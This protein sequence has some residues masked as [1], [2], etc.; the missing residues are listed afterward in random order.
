MRSKKLYMLLCVVAILLLVA[1]SK[2]NSS[3]GGSSS[4]PQSTA[5]GNSAKP[6]E[7]A[8]TKQYKG[9]IIISISKDADNVNAAAFKSLEAAYKKVQPDVKLVWEPGGASSENYKTWLGTQLAGSTPRP[10]IVSGNYQPGY[11]KYADFDKY[12]SRVNPY[13][14]NKWDQ[15][16]NFDFNISFDA[17][18]RRVMLPTQA[19]HIMWFY[20]KDIFD[21]L[22]IKPPQNWDELVSISDKIQKAG[23]IPIA[24][25]YNVKLPQ[26]LHEIYFDQYHKD[27]NNVVRAQ[28][29][30]YNYDDQ[31]DGVFQYN[32]NDPFIETKYTYNHNRF[33]K[34]LVDGAISF[35]NPG[36]IEMIRNL[37]KVFPKYSQK[38]L[39]VADSTADYTLW[40][41]QK[42]AMIIDSSGKLIGI[43][44]DMKNLND[45]VRLEKL[46][47]SDKSLK[48]FNWSTFENPSM[49]G[50]YVQGNVRSVESSTGEYVSIIDKNQEKTEMVMDFVMFW[51]SKPGYQAWIDGQKEIGSF[52]LGGPIM[53]NNVELPAEISKMFDGIQ[54]LGNA[55][56]ELNKNMLVGRV[57]DLKTTGRD[58]FKQALEGSITPEDYAKKFQKLWIDNIGVIT[59][60]AGLTQEN[61]DHPE[62]Q[63]NN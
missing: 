22:G 12:R 28:K 15:D 46:K 40:L 58:L 45:P 18:N 33:L 62:R 56:I 1:C 27:W 38:D 31:K 25:N 49:T 13:T 23:Y 57:P 17:K 19:A 55:E 4:S 21:S 8:S 5:A 41:Q 51:L 14:Q 35:D 7:T 48:A 53:V 2:E 32:A 42:A 34:A 52:M 9:E 43:N 39:F 36:H 26:W 44:E 24:T 11:D 54:V 47:I 59:T 29:G 16:L 30:D 37:A 63:P 10:D 61:I 20:N 3:P 50:K 6:Q 60:R